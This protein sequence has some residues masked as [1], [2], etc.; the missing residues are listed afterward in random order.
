MASYLKLGKIVSVH[1][2]KGELVVEHT[3]GK[4]SSLKNLEVLYVEEQKDKLLPYFIQ[5]TRKKTATEVFIQLDGIDVREKAQRLVSKI[6]WIP[7]EEFHR[8]ASKSAPASLLGFQIIDNG[9]LIGEIKEVI[10][11]PQ[12]LLCKIIVQHKEVLIPLHEDTLI[13]IDYPKQEVHVQLPEGLLDI[14]LS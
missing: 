5:T 4:S 13:K 10:E 14:Y 3:L 8:L 2:L 12:Q 9:N 1:G 7:E 6:V 11:Q